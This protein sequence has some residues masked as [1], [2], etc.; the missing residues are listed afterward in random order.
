MM[1]KGITHRVVRV[2]AP[3]SGISPE[4]K[5]QVNILCAD[6]MHV[7]T[8]VLGVDAEM[9]KEIEWPKQNQDIPLFCERVR[10]ETENAIVQNTYLLVVV[11]TTASTGVGMQVAMAERRGVPAILLYN[12][13]RFLDGHVSPLL[14]SSPVFGSRIIDF[15]DNSN[16]LTQLRLMLMMYKDMFERYNTPSRALRLP[17]LPARR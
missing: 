8:E 4:L 2:I 11:A 3:L 7:C 9:P 13:Q 12:S 15:S 5:N 6:V 17:E 16:A 1:D 14:L 10:V